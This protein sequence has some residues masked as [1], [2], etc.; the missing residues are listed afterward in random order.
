M[1]SYSGAY[2]FLLNEV[3]NQL[4]PQSLTLCQIQR[5]KK[6]TDEGQNNKANY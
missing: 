4:D 6:N 5:S 2:S 1:L 3:Q